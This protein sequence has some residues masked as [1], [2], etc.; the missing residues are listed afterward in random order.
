MSRSF[1]VRLS[2]FFC[3]GAFA[4][5][6]Q[7]VAVP[8][9]SRQTGLACDA[10]H[11][12]YPGLTAFG[13]EF[14]LNGYQIS[15]L[16]QVS[17]QASASAPG[18]SINRIP[19]LSVILQ[20]G[21]EALNRSVSGTQNPA[22]DFPKEFGVYYAGKIAPH[23]GTFLQVTYDSGGS[24]S[25]DSSDVRYVRHTQLFGQYTI[26]ALDF[27]NGPTI[28]DVWNTTPAYSWPYVGNDAPVSAAGPFIGSDAVQHNVLGVGAY[29]YWDN[30]IYT[31]V[32]IYQSA[33]QGNTPATHAAIHGA[34]PY[35]RIAVTPLPNLE[36]GSFGFFANY[37]PGPLKPDTGSRYDD[38]G[39][40]AQYQWYPTVNSIFTFHASYVHQVHNGLDRAYP[41]YS[42]SSSLATNFVNLN[43]NWYFRHRYGLGIGY[44][45]SH[46]DKSSF[47]HFIDPGNFRPLSLPDTNG[48]IVE[49]DYFPYE[50]TRLSLQYIAYN[51]FDGAASDY[52]GQGRSASD[53][54]TWL[55]NMLFGF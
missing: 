34:A 31:Y 33:K 9:F 20:V 40:D 36:I 53:N 23:L 28:E 14:K 12:S 19:N 44:F 24:F 2:L 29:Q 5:T 39:F 21:E 52:N 50:N 15:T 22:A 27:N 47:Y 35:Y 43:G 45:Y 38:I 55:F 46:G 32:G 10:C 6:S 54:N 7:A 17:H 18:L 51:K 49:L 37:R 26:W 3:V 48:E 41:G 25:M 11:T 30:L 13:R 16:K 1:F 8:S 4:W 42:G